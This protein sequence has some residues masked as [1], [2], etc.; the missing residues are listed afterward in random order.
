MN[1]EDFLAGRIVPGH[2]GV[3]RACDQKRGHWSSKPEQA[4]QTTQQKH[5]RGWQARH[6]L[7]GHRRLVTD[8]DWARDVGRLQ[9]SAQVVM[10]V[11]H[12][13]AIPLDV[14]VIRTTS[15]LRGG[16]MRAR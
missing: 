9:G 5:T 11:L 14:Q 8:G 6:G 4:G 3:D 2:D 1:A 16:H 15:D 7:L 10:C 13:D 12:G